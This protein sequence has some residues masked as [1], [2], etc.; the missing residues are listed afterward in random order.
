MSATMNAT[1]I[2]RRL[3]NLQQRRLALV[4]RQDQ[5]RRTLPEWAFAPLELVGMSAKEIRDMMSNLSEAESSSGLDAL[6]AE[7]ESLD[8]EIEEAESRLLTIPSLN[9]EDLQSVLSIAVTRM[10]QNVPSDPG[11]VF[12][13]HGD[14]RCLQFLERAFEDLN[15]MI[16]SERRD[17]A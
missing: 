16:G 6:E 13:D 8:R 10:R 1:L 11:D 2:V 3:G 15:E 4:E 14:M 5:L 9:L 17:S 12:Y 7:I